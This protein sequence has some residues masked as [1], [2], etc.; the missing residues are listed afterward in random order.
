M[1]GLFGASLSEIAS[2]PGPLMGG[3]LQQ[4]LEGPGYELKAERALS[5][6]AVA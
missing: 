4:S 1:Q 5:E 3:E 2:Y 6:Q